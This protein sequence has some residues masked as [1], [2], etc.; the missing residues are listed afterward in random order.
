MASRLWAMQF[1]RQFL[2]PRLIYWQLLSSK[3]HM[4]PQ[5]LKLNLKHLVVVV[6]QD[7][8][9][10]V[11]NLQDLTNLLLN[12]QDR[13]HKELEDFHLS[14][15]LAAEAEAAITVLKVD[16]NINKQSDDI[17]MISRSR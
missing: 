2:Y 3:Q 10:L 14:H 4:L 11:L 17:R 16:T 9:N 8:I 12:L 5:C 13:H 7:L 1:R 15:V 6:L